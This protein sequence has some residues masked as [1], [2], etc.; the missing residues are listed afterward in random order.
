MSDEREYRVPILTYHSIDDSGSVISTSRETFRRQMRRLSETGYRTISLKDLARDLDDKRPFPANTVVITFD[1]GYQNVYAE[2]FPVLAEYGFRATVFLITDYCG[3]TNAWPGNG[4]GI[5]RQQL[6]SWREIKEMQQQ[7]FEFGSHTA[8][9]LDL[10]KV[11]L[12]L[13]EDELQRSRMAIEERLGEEASVFAYPYGSYNSAIRSIVRK[14]FVA[15]C[16]TRLGKVD[17][18]SDPFLLKRVDTYY[19]ST[20]RMFG[21]LAGRSLERYLQ[22]R[23]GLRGVKTL[24]RRLSSQSHAAGVS[25]ERKASAS[26]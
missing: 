14:H 17:S 5:P 18:A 25:V 11:S 26:N 22:F 3:G 4:A 20:D 6:L 23:Q 10:T 7:G 15:A 12:D 8:T 16:S 1:D 24:G 21:A 9:H 13:A 19:L 2:A